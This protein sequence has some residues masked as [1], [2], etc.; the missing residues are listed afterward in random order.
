MWE[1]CFC[2]DCSPHRNAEEAQ[3]EHEELREQR[4]FER[5]MAEAGFLGCC[6]STRFAREMALRGPFSS[7]DFA[8]EAARDIWWNKVMS[9]FP[10]PFS[11]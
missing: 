11:H 8:V 6:G 3:G 1:Q 4:E 10:L 7:L 9:H 5:A 2:F